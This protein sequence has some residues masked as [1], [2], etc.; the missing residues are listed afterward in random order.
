MTNPTFG[1]KKVTALINWKEG[2]VPLFFKKRT[3]DAILAVVNL[4][5]AESFFALFPPAWK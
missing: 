2:I 1:D 3:Y 5:M 4:K